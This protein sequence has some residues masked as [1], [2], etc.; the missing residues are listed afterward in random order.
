MALLRLDPTTWTWVITG[1]P[2]I[3]GDTR[4]TGGSCPF[5]PESE[6]YV[7]RAIA[8]RLGRDGK[9]AVRAFHDRTPILQIEGE[10]GRHA[11][12]MFDTMNAVGAHEIIVE[13]P[14]H[15]RTLA[16]QGADLLEPVLDVY[17][18]RITDLKRDQRFRYVEVFKN[19]GRL[20]GALVE[21]PHSQLL[22]T[23]VLPQ[24]VERELRAARAHYEQKE[25]CLY[26]DILRQE[27]RQG[28]RLVEESADFLAFCPFASRYPYE[29]W[30]LPKTHNSSFETMVAQASLRGQLARIFASV[31][32]RVE[33]VSRSLHFV[34]H[35]EPNVSVSRVFAV[36]WQSV[37]EDFHWHI[38]LMPRLDRRQKYLR[39]EEFFLN[40]VTPE[41]AAHV[42]REA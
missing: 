38:E 20:A 10:E 33:K 16:E 22:A 36:E 39:E 29:L 32:R 35:T 11:E 26:C 14:E 19:Q 18:E 4:D 24:R 21:H 2:M 17:T 30:L 9:W 15:A 31:L 25:R 8:E 5:C 42:L 6:A 27:K 40:T 13:G 12:G 34:V 28:V 1:E 3:T 41:E 7:P 23:P 37:R